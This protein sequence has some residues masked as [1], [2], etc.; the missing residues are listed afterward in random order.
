[1]SLQTPDK[2]RELQRALYTKA[3]EEK[4]YRFY[5]LYDKVHRS[6][7]L[8]RAYELV[9]E[10]R[11]AAG[12][13][14]ETFESIKEKGLES[15][16]KKLEEE[17]REK[18]Y[19]PEAVRRVMIPKP[20]GGE[21][22]LGIPTIKDR[23]AQMAAKLILEP[24]FEADFED[25]AYGY[26]PKRSALDAVE[27]VHEALCEGYTEV[28]DADLSKYF[29]TIPHHELM[30]SVAR[31]VVDK[32]M[33]H[34]V[35]M[36]LKVPVQ[37]TTKNG[38][39]T[40]SGGKKT[41]RGTPQ[42][43]VISPLLANIYM[44]RFL[45]AWREK[46]KGEQLKA[47]IVSYAD[48]FVVLT[49]QKAQ[50]ALQWVDGVMT[51]IGLKLNTEKTKIRDATKSTF[52]FLGYTFGPEHYR[53]DG[54]WYMA[55]QPSAKSVARVK[56]KIRTVLSPSNNAEWEVVQGRLNRILSGWSRYF[57][58]GTRL[59]AYRAV[60]NFV[61]ERVKGFLCRRHKVSGRGTLQFSD[62]VVFEERGV[63]R[64]RTIQLGAPRSTL[65]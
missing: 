20:G 41:Q 63:L 31:R 3:K 42:G 46:G 44:H 49:K 35:K 29:D 14:G 6:D 48:D 54:H 60:D 38:K 1:M 32:H 61:Y 23:T 50:E 5:A 21:R 45:R 25:C 40:I 65:V 2:I 53:K 24:I 33:L 57:S 36:W 37:E 11:G 58:Y 34:L 39:T 9:K 7:I 55:A 22:P 16:L 10:N 26:R 62:S 27:E 12:V 17:L 43:G 15:W 30:Q 47:K 56:E 51:K 64:L 18:R 19:K 59:F 28:V 13:D 4:E 8:R 52:D